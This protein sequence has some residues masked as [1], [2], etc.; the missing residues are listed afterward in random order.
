MDPRPPVRVDPGFGPFAPQIDCD[1]IRAEH[2]R[3][4]AAQAFGCVA[5]QIAIVLT[6]CLVAAIFTMSFWHRLA[7]YEAALKNCAGV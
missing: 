2:N 3:A 5:A 1:A 6:G 4:A 7:V